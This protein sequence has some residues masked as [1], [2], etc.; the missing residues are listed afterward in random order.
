MQPLIFTQLFVSQYQMVKKITLTPT[1]RFKNA[2]L[3][4]NQGLHLLYRPNHKP[5]Q[6]RPLQIG[7]DPLT[8]HERANLPAKKGKCLT[9]Q[10]QLG[11]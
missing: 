6:H 11:D 4:H 10:Y 5:L 3:C 2:S 1:C 9:S 7:N 8:M